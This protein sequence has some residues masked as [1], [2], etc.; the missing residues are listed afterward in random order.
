MSLYEVL[1]EHCFSEQ[2]EK[3]KAIYPRIYEIK[4]AIIWTLS[5]NPILGTALPH[6]PDFKVFKSDSLNSE[7]QGFWLL[8]K[9]EKD[10][11]RVRL[12][13]IAPIDQKTD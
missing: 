10:R 9:N 6:S 8:F 13:S 11:E 1:E 12:F 7:D 4:D 2:I 3:L 5:R